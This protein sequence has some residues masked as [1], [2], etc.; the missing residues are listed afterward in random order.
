MV[1][2]SVFKNPFRVKEDQKK[3]VLERHFEM[4][5]KHEDQRTI[6]GKKV[7]WNFW[8][9]H[10]RFGSKC[11]FA[12]DS[13]VKQRSFHQTESNR[14]SSGQSMA[15]PRHSFNTPL[16]KIP[17]PGSRK[18]TSSEIPEDYDEDKHD[19]DSS[20]AVI[21]CNKKSKKRPGL[22]SGLVPSKKAMKF[23]DKV[24]N[25]KWWKK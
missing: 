10:C 4:T 23:H 3:A 19:F 8:K 7:C 24:Y 17:L 5:V 16:F 15:A 21:E 18:D 2:N 25:A 14:E 13:D 6:D 9:G 11:I 20:D 12:H 22:S 1:E